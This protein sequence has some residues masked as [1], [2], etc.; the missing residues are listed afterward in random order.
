M[1][2]A[3]EWIITI[4]F[5]MEYIVRIWASPKPW[6]YIFSFYGIIDF[7]AI[8]PDKDVEDNKVMKA[9]FG[10]KAGT[11]KNTNENLLAEAG[12][13]LIDKGAE[14][15][16]LGCTE[17]PLAFNPLRVDVPVVSATGVLADRSIQ[18][19]NE[20]KTRIKY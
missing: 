7:L 20:L 19:Y 8:I 15:I 16:I 1:L 13:H 14:V 11:G 10:I 9:V 2:K 4:I 6:R 18:M 17:I 12:Q 3:A 5:S